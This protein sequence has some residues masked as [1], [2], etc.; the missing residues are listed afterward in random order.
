[1]TTKLHYELVIFP[2]KLVIPPC[3][4]K[5]HSFCQIK[6]RP[7]LLEEIF[8]ADNKFSLL[9]FLREGHNSFRYPDDSEEQI[10]QKCGKFSEERLHR[11]NGRRKPFI[12]VHMKVRFR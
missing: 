6:I 12:K 7:V 8:K 2:R 5:K 1:M 9:S 11:Q 3:S 4:F 10:P